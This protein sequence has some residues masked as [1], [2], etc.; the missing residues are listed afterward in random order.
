MFDLPVKNLMEPKKLIM[1]SPETSVS[2]VAVLMASKNTGA[3]LVIEDK[4]LIGI[5]TERD[6]VFRVLA[7]GRDAATTRLRDVMT[8]APST[9]A[10]GTS[11]GHALLLMQEKGFRHVP[12]VDGDRVLGIIASRNAMDPQLEEFVSEARRREHYREADA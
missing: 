10:P 12:I 9:V 2:D 5:F 3:V 11:Y 6:V 7:K 8:A 1:V 4:L